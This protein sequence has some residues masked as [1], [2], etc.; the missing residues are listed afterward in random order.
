MKKQKLETVVSFGLAFALAA[1]LLVGCGEVSPET[2]TIE[3]TMVPQ[4]ESVPELEAP[5]A[6]VEADMAVEQGVYEDANGWSVKYDPEVIT[7]NNGGPI[8]TFVYTGESAGT[9]MITASYNVDS[10]AKTAIDELAKEWGSAAQTHESVFPGTE[11]VTGYWAM[12]LP[13]SEG[14]GL[15]ETAIAR[16]YMDGYLLF[17]VTGHNCGDDSIDI[18]VSD[19]LAG[20]IDSIEFKN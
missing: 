10:D 14:S 3:E 18:P 12:L 8:S 4:A 7:V 5:A 11:D 6:E 19:A 13:S 2:V 20:I 16:D 1:A 9:N 17:E 15:Y